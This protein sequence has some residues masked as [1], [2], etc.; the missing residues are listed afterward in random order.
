MFLGVYEQKIPSSRGTVP[1]TS[2]Y[3]LE[4]EARQDALTLDGPEILAA[5][6]LPCLS[7]FILWQASITLPERTP[8][9]FVRSLHVGQDKLQC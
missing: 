4:S 3:P 8:L 6:S 1:V 7:R 9:G 2:P 5:R